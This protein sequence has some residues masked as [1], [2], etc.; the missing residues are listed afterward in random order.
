MS[1]ERFFDFC[2]TD[3]HLLLNVFSRPVAQ[4]AVFRLY[5]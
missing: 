4:L 3:D 2:F 5:P 1:L